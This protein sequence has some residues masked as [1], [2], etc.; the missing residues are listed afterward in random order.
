[1]H[2]REATEGKLSGTMPCD[3]GRLHKMVD[4]TDEDIRHLVAVNALDEA[5]KAASRP[6]RLPAHFRL[7]R[8]RV[9]E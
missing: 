4:A 5:S 6:C 9:V 2:C 3:A 7:L 8:E 1:M